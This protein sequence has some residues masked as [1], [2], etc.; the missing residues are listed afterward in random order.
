MRV[1]F[2]R[3]G[4]STANTLRIFSNRTDEHPLTEK[5]RE[6][7]LDLA[8]RLAGIPLAAVYS[9]NVLRA[10]ETSQIVCQQ[11]GLEFTITPALREFDVGNFEGKSDETYWEQFSQLWNDWY[12][13]GL[14]ERNVGGGEN[15]LQIRQR[16][17]DFLQ[18]LLQKFSKQDTVL[19]VCHGGIL[20][21]GVP[22]IAV[23]LHNE[24]IRDLKIA[25]TALLILDYDGKDWRCLQWGD[26]LF[27]Q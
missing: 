8:K 12:G 26:K 2:A 3:H 19:C 22:G 7:A 9:S 16:L 10:V 1:I 13:N 17:E 24:V 21:A 23:N 5:G 14:V 15:L 6:Q 11:L 18:M 25:N 27:P 20:F 4:E